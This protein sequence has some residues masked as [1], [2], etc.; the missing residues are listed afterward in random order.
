VRRNRAPRW[1]SRMSNG[2]VMANLL[3]T[4]AQLPDG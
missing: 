1:I 4:K 3:R 2:P